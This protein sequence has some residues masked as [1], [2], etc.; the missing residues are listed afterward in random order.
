MTNNTFWT[1]ASA[2]NDPSQRPPGPEGLPVLGNTISYIRQPMGFIEGLS[3]YGDIVRCAFPTIDAVVL[4]HPEHIERVLLT[5]QQAYR[6]WNFDQLREI[7]KYDFAP[8]GLAFTGGTQWRKQRRFLQ[9]MFGL[10]RL[11]GFTDAMVEQTDRLIERWDDGE[12]IA[13][14]RVFSELSLR[15]LTHSLFD[16]DVERRG[17]VV[18]RATEALNDY[19]NVRGRNAAELL[20]PSWIPTPRRARYREA[21][22]AFEATIDELIAERRTNPEGYDDLLARILGTESDEYSMS[23]SEIHD[24]LLTF[25]FAGHETTATALT[26]TWLLL[27]THPEQ[28][29][30]LEAEVEDVGDEPPLP[31]DLDALTHTEQVIT[32]A[33]R[34]YPPATTLFRE[35]LAE[36]EIG[37]YTIPENTTILLPQFVVHTDGRWYDDPEAFR[38]ERWSTRTDRPEYAHFPFGGGGHHC[39]GMRFAMLELT[40]VVATI[41]RRVDFELLSDPDPAVQQEIT[42]QPTEDVRA[43]VHKRTR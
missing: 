41:A 27:A 28:R 24:Q 43:R 23:D 26:F 14:N 38:P 2:W 9:P 10:D 29:E 34:L 25:L 21:M 3:E 4:F 33:L 35:T 1:D 16:L 17:D 13:L 20:L 19:A 18:I 40:H 15:I 8:E 5:N 11:R 30:R 36:T 6:R 31:G 12:E 37:G 42:L 32:E 7:R 22:D 39:I